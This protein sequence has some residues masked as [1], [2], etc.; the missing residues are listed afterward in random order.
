MKINSFLSLFFF[1]FVN[2]GE[3]CSQPY[4][5]RKSRNKKEFVKAFVS[6]QGAN[7]SGEFESF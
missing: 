1:F 2:L 6:H 4:L 7:L 3:Q 5:N